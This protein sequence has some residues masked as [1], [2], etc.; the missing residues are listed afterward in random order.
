[1]ALAFIENAKKIA[2]SDNDRMFYRVFEAMIRHDAGEAGRAQ[3]IYREISPQLKDKSP[4]LEKFVK[5]K[6]K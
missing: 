1:M 6:I 4:A 5:D 2:K 3:E